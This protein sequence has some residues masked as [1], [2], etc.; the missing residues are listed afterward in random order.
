MEVLQLPLEGHT[1]DEGE[2]RFNDLDSL[3]VGGMILSYVESD[4]GMRS[5]FPSSVTGESFWHTTSLAQRVEKSVDPLICL[6][7]S[8]IYCSAIRKK[9]MQEH[10]PFRSFEEIRPVI[11]LCV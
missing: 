10:T 3:R 4:E 1:R 2:L 8:C 5:V 11:T 7:C 9:M 6:T